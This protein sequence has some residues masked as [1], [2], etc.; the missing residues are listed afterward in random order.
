MCSSSGK[1]AEPDLSKGISPPARNISSRIP[2]ADLRWID[3]PGGEVLHQAPLDID[4]QA[5]ARLDNSVNARR[6]Q[7]GKADLLPIAVERAR[8]ELGRTALTPVA[9]IALGAMARPEEH[10]KLRP[11]TMISPF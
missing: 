9:L 2:V 5:M 3:L 7:N 11:A 10:P 4:T 8:E 1:I 6:L